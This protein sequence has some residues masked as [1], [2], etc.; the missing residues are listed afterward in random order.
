MEIEDDDDETQEQKGNFA[1]R[2]LDKKR[3][4]EKHLIPQQQKVALAA[5][6][7]SELEE[8]REPKILGEMLSKLLDN[9]NLEEI[10]VDNNPTDSK[11][12]TPLIDPTTHPKNNL[13]LQPLA[14]NHLPNTSN[15]DLSTFSNSSLAATHYHSNNV[16]RKASASHPSAGGGHFIYEKG[17]PA[18][19]FTVILQGK[20]YVKSGSEGFESELGPFTHMG[21]NALTVDH[22]IPDFT[23]YVKE[24]TEVVKIKKSNYLA[25]LKATQLHSL[26]LEGALTAEG[27]INHALSSPSKHHDHPGHASNTIEMTGLRSPHHDDKKTHHLNNSTN[28]EVTSILSSDQLSLSEDNDVIKI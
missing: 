7:A 2:R 9:S 23:A 4:K 13:P 3:E 15:T 16:N 12:L 22:Y 8:F 11:K 14:P 18:D 24:Y 6:L 26:K 19:F 1:L 27:M 17:K 5:Y 10:R 21:L 25:A 20:A 28:E